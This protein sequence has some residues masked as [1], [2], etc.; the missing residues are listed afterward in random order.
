[1]KPVLNS[2]LFVLLTAPLVYV[3]C[4]KE[5]SV[6]NCRDTIRLSIASAGRHTMIVLPVVSVS[7]DGSSSNDRDGSISN[8]EWTKISGPAIF[9]IITLAPARTVVKNLT[10][11]LYQFEL[12]VTDNDAF[13]NRYNTGYCECFS[14]YSL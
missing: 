4:K 14:Q 2:S 3:F 11:G 7:P 12:R 1:M 5:Y 6:E 9:S 13:F 8:Y 10:T